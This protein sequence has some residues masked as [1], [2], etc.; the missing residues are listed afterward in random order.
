MHSVGRVS[1]MQGGTWRAMPTTI[2]GRA[3]RIVPVE[4]VIKPRELNMMEIYHQTR[5]PN[6]RT[7]Q[8]FSGRKTP[9]QSARDSANSGESAGR[10][11]PVRRFGPDRHVPSL[12]G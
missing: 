1:E 9:P 3:A 11:R 12:H 8:D 2:S 7:E 10:K 5:R 4:N 6:T